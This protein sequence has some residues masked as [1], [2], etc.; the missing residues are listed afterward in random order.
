MTDG[1]PAIEEIEDAIPEE[2]KNL[3]FGGPDEDI[4]DVMD[5]WED[6]ETDD[7]EGER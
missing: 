5:R 2:R 4:L 6:E 3:S 7:T 1:K